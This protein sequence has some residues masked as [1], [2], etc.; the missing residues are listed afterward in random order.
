MSDTTTNPWAD[1]PEAEPLEW[2]TEDDK[3]ELVN[4][5]TVFTI[6]DMELWDEGEYGPRYVATIAYGEAGEMLM[7]FKAEPRSM[8]RNKIN[9]WMV[10]GFKAKKFDKVQAVLV[11]KGRAYSFADPDNIPF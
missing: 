3:K 2:F 1:A 9:Q 7:A 5:G 8:P 10:D 4:N 6:I 11:K